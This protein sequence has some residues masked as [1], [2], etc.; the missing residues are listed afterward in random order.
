MVRNRPLIDQAADA[1]QLP[2]APAAAGERPGKR[3]RHGFTLPEVL[4]AMA[5]IGLLASYGVPRLQSFM[6]DNR[7]AAELNRFNAGLRQARS[8]AVTR[9][10]RAV[11][12]KR[13]TDTRCHHTADSYAWENGWLIFIDTDGDDRYDHDGSEP[14]LAVQG[15]L[16]NGNTLRSAHPTATHSTHDY[17]AFDALGRTNIGAVATVNFWLCDR[18]GA[19]RAVGINLRGTGQLRAATATPASCTP[20]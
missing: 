5:I 15:A 16:G 2:G 8:E 18:R 6:L 20:H 17:V 12:C 4:T 10:A 19:D 9:S 1:A 11:I 3:C 7:L 13:A 14:L